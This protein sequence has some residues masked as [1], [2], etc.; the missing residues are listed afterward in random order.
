MSL[1]HLLFSRSPFPP[2]SSIIGDR[3]IPDYRQSDQES[4][5]H[6]SWDCEEVIP[7]STASPILDLARPRKPWEHPSI[8]I[9]VSGPARKPRIMATPKTL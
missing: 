5:H 9:T 2:P 8:P 4:P 3:R 6:R 1:F 7:R